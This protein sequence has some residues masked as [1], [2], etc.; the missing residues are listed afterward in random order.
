MVKQL[1]IKLN[2]SAVTRWTALILVSL[3]M[4][5]AYMFAD[6]MSPLQ[7][8]VET[9]RG[10][11]PNVFGT[12]GSAPYMLNVFGFLILAGII[13][14]KCGVRFT[15]TLSASLMIIGAGIKYYGIREGF[16]GTGLEVWLSSWWVSFP[17]SA[18]LSLFGFMI[19]GCGMEMAG[20]TISKAIVKWFKG[21]ELAMAMGIEMAIARLGVFALFSMPAVL[22]KNFEISEPVALCTLLLIIGLLSFIVFCVMDK[23]LDKQLGAD[24][25]IEPEEA[26]KVSDIV[27]IFSSKMFWIIALL[28]VLYYSAIFPFQKFATNMLQS[29]LNIDATAASSIFRWLPMGAMILT[30]FMGWFLDRKGKG[31]SMLILGAILMIVCHLIFAFVLPVYP[32]QSLAY[33]TIVVLGISFSLV[34]ASLWPSVPKVMDERFLG[35][36]YSLIFWVQNI[37]LMLTPIVIG[38][39][40]HATNPGVADAIQQGVEGVKYDY[41]MPMIIFAG[42]GVM[43]LFVAIWLKA[44]DRKGKFGLELP[45]IQK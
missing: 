27:K 23:K 22:G 32:S 14:D 28:C 34:P 21:K 17:A 4:F 31:A 20:I 45:N 15:G 19:F 33:A 5:F 9:Q 2:D 30:P 8:L 39:V 40:L 18:K 42:F 26:F 6:I 10:W 12:Y 29:C 43:A 1:Q 37:G 7:S 24:A 44:V 36:A 41:T 25:S 16:E 13:L 3:L 35:S 38:K 11:G